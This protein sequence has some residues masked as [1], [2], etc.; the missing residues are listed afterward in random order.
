MA[1]ELETFFELQYS[2]ID[3]VN[4][5]KTNDKTLYYNEL[6]CHL[7]LIF[8]IL[9][10]IKTDLHNEKNYNDEC[11]F[12]NYIMNGWTQNQNETKMNDYLLQNIKMVNSFNE[13]SKE[14][15]I[16]YLEIVLLDRFEKNDNVKRTIVF[17]PNFLLK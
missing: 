16:N 14:I 15:V 1:L 5:N 7:E 8:D 11:K 6:S 13:K 17:R 9:T 10:A 4:K 12:S 2:E 3:I